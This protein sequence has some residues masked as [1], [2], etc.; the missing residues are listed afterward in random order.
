VSLTPRSE[1]SAPSAP[2]Q[3]SSPAGDEAPVSVPEIKY[4]SEI[5]PE[6]LPF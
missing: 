4:E 5:K 3:K 6:D 1:S 2:S